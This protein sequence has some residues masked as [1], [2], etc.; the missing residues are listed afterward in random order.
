MNILILVKKY[1][2]GVGSVVKALKIN[3]ENQGD[4]VFIISREDDNRSI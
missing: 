2:G 3:F 4:K 1:E